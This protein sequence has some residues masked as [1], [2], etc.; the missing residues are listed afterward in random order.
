M[1]LAIVAA[2]DSESKAPTKFRAAAIPT[3]RRGLRAPVAIEV[4][5]AFPVSWNPFVKSNA[6]A[7]ATTVPSSTVFVSIA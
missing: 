1:P 3:A 4:A 6:S 5:I 2:T 7:V